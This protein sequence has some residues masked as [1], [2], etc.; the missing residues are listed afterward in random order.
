MSVPNIY[1]SYLTAGPNPV[2][3][4]SGSASN[5]FPTGII[6]MNAKAT[7]PSGWLACD[8]TAVSKTTYADLYAF[9]GANAFGTDTS[10]DFYLPSFNVGAAVKFPVGASNTKAFHSTGGA[11]NHVHGNV[12]ITNTISTESLVHDHDTSYGNPDHSHSNSNA[13]AYNGNDG[14]HN[15]GINGASTAGATSNTTAN[16]GGGSTVVGGHAHGINA[17]STNGGGGAAH[18][19]SGM[20]TGNIAGGTTSHNHTITGTSVT[21]HTHV[22][23]HPT[24]AT[25]SGAN[26]PPY[27]MIQ[28][29]I[30]T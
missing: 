13:T 9:I 26:I 11:A 6:I 15:H 23:S 30:K 20:S 3:E 14:D 24:A 25:S 4:L 28:F 17:P 10:T 21:S 18:N 1:P 12:A 5:P 19:W 22:G 7:T 29:I 8:G 16:S 2:I 27:L